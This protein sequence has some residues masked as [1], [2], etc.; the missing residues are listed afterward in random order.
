MAI[1]H[2]PL[3]YTTPPPPIT[4]AVTDHRSPA[5]LHESGAVGLVVTTQ[6]RRGEGRD[7]LPRDLGKPCGATTDPPTLNGERIPRCLGESRD[8]VGHQRV[9][10]LEVIVAL[11]DAD[12]GHN[13]LEDLRVE[14]GEVLI[15]QLGSGLTN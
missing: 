10:R 13:R 4:C 1:T 3:K 11:E 14:Q 2:T 15:V 9:T 12:F 6:P 7:G 5:Q 8:W